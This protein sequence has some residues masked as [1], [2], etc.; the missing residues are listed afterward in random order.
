MCMTCGC[1]RA[2]DDHSDSRNITL[3]DLQGAANAANITLQDAASNIQVTL[4]LVLGA[5]SDT[6]SITKALAA[7]PD[8]DAAYR[9]VKAQDEKRYT[10]GLAYGANLPDVARAADGFR[11]FASKDAIQDAAWRYMTKSR[12]IGLGHVDGT[13]AAGEVV[14]SYTWP[15]D[16]WIMKASDGTEVRIENGD[17]LLGVIWTPPAWSLIKSG[18]IRGF[19]PQGGA[20]RRSPSADALDHLR[21]R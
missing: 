3:T 7:H 18:D 16:T 6:D 11:D 17:W 5:A 2:L 9:L 8:A 13:D 14:E 1:G 15:A 10:L 19:S 20:K 4:A 12:N 21:S